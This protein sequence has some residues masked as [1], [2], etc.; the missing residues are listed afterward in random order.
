MLL[1]QSSFEGGNKSSD[2][3][4]KLNDAL[5]S[6]SILF[7]ALKNEKPKHFVEVDCDCFNQ[8]QSTLRKNYLLKCYNNMLEIITN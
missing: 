7:W 2:F 8:N 1:Q 6:A 4:G 3:F 5:V